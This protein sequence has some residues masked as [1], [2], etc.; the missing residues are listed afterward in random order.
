[1]AEKRRNAPDNIPIIGGNENQNRHRDDVA[2]EPADN[3]AVDGNGVQPIIE[4][5]GDQGNEN[6]GNDR[7]NLVAVNHP[8][9]YRR[10]AKK[11]TKLLF[12]PPAVFNQLSVILI[13][14]GMRLTYPSSIIMLKGN[15]LFS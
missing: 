14:F 9:P 13:Y 6:V 10:R 7:Q 5:I 3:H 15:G 4:D 8:R 1:M 12:F 2:A 11:Y